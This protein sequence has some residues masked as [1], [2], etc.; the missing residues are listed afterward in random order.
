M[1]SAVSVGESRFSDGS[2][3]VVGNAPG[4]LKTEGCVSRE[5]IK[6]QIRWTV[7]KQNVGI[8]RHQDP[9]LAA[10]ILQAPGGTLSIQPAK[11]GMPTALVNSRYLHSAYDPV[12]EAERWAEERMK[13]CQAGETIVVLGVGLLYHVQALRQ[14][15]SHDHVIMV[16]VPDLSEFADCV[17]VRSLGR[18]G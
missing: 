2:L 8:L 11:S 18:V 4:S 9:I 16:V 17:S 14:V 1:G 12:R 13:D 15:L 6:G 10:Q 5:I 3:E 7:L